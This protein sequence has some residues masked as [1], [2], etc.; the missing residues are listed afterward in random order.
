MAVK[1]AG[2]GGATNPN[3]VIAGINWVV[4]NADALDI[5]V[6]NLS[7]SS[8]S[9]LPYQEDAL[10]AALER[11]WQA[12][13]VVVTAAGNDG[14][15]AVGLD[16][17]ANDPHFIA[18]GGVRAL[19]DGFEIWESSSQGDGVR[20]PDV[21]APGAHIQSL[22]APGSDADINHAEGFVDNETFL[23]SGTSQ[24]AAVVAGSAALLLEAHPEWTNDQV[25]SALMTTAVPLA[26]VEETL[27]GNGV[28][29]VDLA[30]A[31]TDL[32]QPN[33]WPLAVSGD[34]GALAAPTQGFASLWTGA[35]WTGAHWT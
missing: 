21:A 34:A 8:G 16:S 10:T 22:R 28:I 4:D 20:N 31:A 5:K 13:I 29:R 2:S 3:D 33:T 7:F 32:S 25:K 9:D 14:P 24:S 26:G 1:V 15:D 30:A 19:D 12:G 18:V 35:H 11:A 6:L 17:P 23:G 27:Q